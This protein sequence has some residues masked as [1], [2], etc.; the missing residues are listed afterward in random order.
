MRE[1]IAETIKASCRS[2]AQ[3][4]VVMAKCGTAY[5]TYVFHVSICFSCLAYI[6]P[7]CCWHPALHTWKH[8]RRSKATRAITRASTTYRVSATFMRTHQSHHQTVHGAQS[9]SWRREKRRVSRTESCATFQ[10]GVEISHQPDAAPSCTAAVRDYMRTGTESGCTG[11]L[12]MER[13]NHWARWSSMVGAVRYAC[14]GH[15][16]RSSKSIQQIG[17]ADK[18]SAWNGAQTLSLCG[19][20]F[21]VWDLDHAYVCTRRCVQETTRK[22]WSKTDQNMATE[23]V[24]PVLPDPATRGAAHQSS[25]DKDHA[26]GSKDTLHR[27]TMEMAPRFTGFS[28]ILSWCLNELGPLLPVSFTFCVACRSKFALVPKSVR[29]NQ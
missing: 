9:R 16:S 18:I 4:M 17:T 27:A 25:A 26:L 24:A 12:S 7:I 15:G 20:S 22:E 19:Q 14:Q 5:S 10:Q 23:T 8:S 13:S 21:T 29:L 1:P 2:C 11:K 3:P 6:H 28:V